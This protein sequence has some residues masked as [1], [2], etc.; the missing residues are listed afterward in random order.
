MSQ[1]VQ[2]S[3]RPRRALD[4]KSSSGVKMKQR[5]LLGY[6]AAEMGHVAP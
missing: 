2:Y 1:S 6:L 5:H 4:E 3:C